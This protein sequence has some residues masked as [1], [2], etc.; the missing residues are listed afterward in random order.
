M[1]MGT[2]FEFYIVYSICSYILASQTSL[3]TTFGFQLS[4]FSKQDC[5]SSRGS[6]L[7]DLAELLILFVLS[8]PFDSCASIMGE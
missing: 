5:F 4:D 7:P 3:R 6:C 1:F 2:V 8:F